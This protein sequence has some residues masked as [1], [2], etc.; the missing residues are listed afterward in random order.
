MP[1]WPPS[2]RIL[3]AGSITLAALAA[4]IVPAVASASVVSSGLGPFETAFE[5]QQSTADAA[6]FFGGAFNVAGT[7][8]ALEAGN[9]GAPYLMATQ[10][11]ALAAPFIWASGKEV[12]P[13]GGFTGTIPEPSLPALKNMI[14]MS[15]VHTFLQ[16]PTTADPRLASIARNCLKVTKRSGPAPVLPIGVYYCGPF[17]FLKSLPAGDTP[18]VPPETQTANPDT[19]PACPVAGGQGWG[20][21]PGAGSR[22]GAAPATGGRRASG[23][24]RPRHEA[25]RSASRSRPGPA[26]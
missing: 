8:P 22:E 19:A 7:L 3:A 10:T 13:V 14:E 26:S 9:R 17:I 24:R 12:L 16:S 5:S 18:R 6:L 1:A 25:G 21:S 4:L 11:S 20:T 15:D 23:R 2:R